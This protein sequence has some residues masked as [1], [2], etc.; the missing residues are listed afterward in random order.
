M[1]RKAKSVAA[2]KV[3]MISGR[4]EVPAKLRRRYLDIVALTDAFCNE[5]LDTEYL[6]LCREMA[7][8]VCQDGSPAERGKAASWASGIV[9][10]IGWVN[11]F[12]DR[13]FEPYIRSEEIAEWFGVSTRARCRASQRRSAMGWTSVRSIPTSRI[14]AG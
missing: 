3:P 5:R 9:A 2:E 13:S 4:E 14:R 7:I 6:E 8:G 1:G 12:G 10:A 11:F